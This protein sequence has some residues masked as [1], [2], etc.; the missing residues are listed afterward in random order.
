M[1]VVSRTIILLLVEGFYEHR[2]RPPSDWKELYQLAVVELDP[3]K[4][5]QRITEARNAILNKVAETVTKARDYHESQELTDALN[6][7]RVLHQ[8]HQRRV[9]PFGEPRQRIG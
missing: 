5:P 9:Q 2:R 8:E 4:L 3:A 6:G 7:L 1:S